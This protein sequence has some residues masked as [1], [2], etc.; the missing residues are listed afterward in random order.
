MCT[1]KLNNLQK[2]TTETRNLNVTLDYPKELV[3]EA[4]LQ[5]IKNKST[6]IVRYSDLKKGEIFAENNYLFSMTTGLLLGPFGQKLVHFAILLDGSNPTNV[7]II[8]RNQGIANEDFKQ[9]ILNEAKRLL[10]KDI[11]K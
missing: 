10:E 2:D 9:N 6:L 8:Q 7:R 1:T 11:L 4:F 5:A 3:F